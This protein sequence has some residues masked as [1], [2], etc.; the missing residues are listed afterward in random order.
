M[1]VP[2]YLEHLD[3]SGTRDGWPKWVDET[4]K[5]YAVKQLKAGFAKFGQMDLDLAKECIFSDAPQTMKPKPECLKDV[6]L[7][8]ALYAVTY[9]ALLEVSAKQI[10][11]LN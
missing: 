1:Y 4:A 2:S 10:W 9:R 5:T 7:W 8:D 3:R 6:A 11:K